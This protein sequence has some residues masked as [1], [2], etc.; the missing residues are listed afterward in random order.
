MAK[1][2]I[3]FIINPD[4]ERLVHPCTRRGTKTT[5]YRSSLLLL[6]M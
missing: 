1:L 2:H 5:Q 6:Q 3:H 4:K